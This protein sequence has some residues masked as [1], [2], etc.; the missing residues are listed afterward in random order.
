MNKMNDTLEKLT[1]F[2]GGVFIG[3]IFSWIATTNYL[4]K[5]AVKAGAGHYIM[6]EASGNS[7]FHW[8]NNKEGK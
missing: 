6:S 2:A 1:V 4:Q 5:E 7:V 3:C 8:I